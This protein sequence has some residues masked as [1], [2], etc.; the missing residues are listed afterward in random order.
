[1]D[2]R[3][4]NEFWEY[5]LTDSGAILTINVV[6]KDADIQLVPSDDVFMV[7]GTFDGAEISGIITP[8]RACVRSGRGQHCI[9][10]YNFADDVTFN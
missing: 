9:T 4:W 3:K 1:M 5:T 2:T 8:H 6:T 10:A 7:F